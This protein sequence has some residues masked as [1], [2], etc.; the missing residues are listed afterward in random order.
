MLTHAA[1]CECLC[2]PEEWWYTT[3][4]PVLMYGI[5][6][7]TL[8]KAE[9]DMLERTEKMQLRWMVGIERNKKIY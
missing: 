4:T 2:T 6:I 1:S 8:R 3:T 7:W 9:Q 5:E